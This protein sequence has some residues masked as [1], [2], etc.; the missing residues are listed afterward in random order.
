MAEL[1]PCPF[2]GGRANFVTS[3]GMDNVASNVAKFVA[4]SADVEQAD[5]L[6]MDI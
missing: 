4:L 6:L 5:I 1:K 3:R 2:C